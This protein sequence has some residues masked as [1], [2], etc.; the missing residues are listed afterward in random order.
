MSHLSAFDGP[1][2]FVTLHPVFSLGALFIA[3][4]A[5]A[6]VARRKAAGPSV[7]RRR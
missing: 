4:L 6:L 1:L 5:V 7:G 3:S 2:G